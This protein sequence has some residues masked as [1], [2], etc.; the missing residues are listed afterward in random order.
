MN[1]YTVPGTKCLASAILQMTFRTLQGGT[2]TKDQ[3]LQ[4]TQ[5]NKETLGR[6][7]HPKSPEEPD[8]TP[9]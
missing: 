1:V 5:K 3:D 2:G 9:V 4:I 7:K 6:I 8:P